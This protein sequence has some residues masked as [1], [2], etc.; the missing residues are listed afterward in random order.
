MVAVTAYAKRTIIK[1]ELLNGGNDFPEIRSHNFAA[2]LGLEHEHD[3]R[4]GFR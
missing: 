4:N 3:F 1:Q 2:R